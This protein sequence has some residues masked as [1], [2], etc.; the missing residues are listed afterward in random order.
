[1][2]ERPAPTGPA[3]TGPAPVAQDTP[4]F[5]LNRIGAMVLRYVYLFKGSWPRVL[6]LT[7]WP[8]MQMVL[9][10]FITLYLLKLNT[11]FAQATGILIAAVLLWDVLFRGQLGVAISFLE[12]MWSRNLGHIFVSPLRPGEFIVSLMIMSL[13]RT[14]IGVVPA[15][16]LAIWLYDISVFDMGLPLLAFFVNLQV[17]GWSI[18]LFVCG[19]LMRWGL[20]AESIAWLAIFAIAPFSGIYYPLSVMPDWLQEIVRILPSAHVFEGMRAVLLQHTFR[21]DLLFN[22]VALNVAYL[23]AGVAAFLYFFKLSRRH[24]LILQIGE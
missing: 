1:M 12:E 5:S 24:G 2:P 19:V 6:E 21:L 9:W 10:G 16:L 11:F 20:G 14:L 23:A 13:I 18:G 15:A 7:Y 4:A 17:M 22:A 8:T 3:P